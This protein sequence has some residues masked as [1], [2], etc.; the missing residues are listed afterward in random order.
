[1]SASPYQSDEKQL[2]KKRIPTMRKSIK[3]G[4]GG[5]SNVE[6]I[7]REAYQNISPPSIDDLQTV[8]E[9]RNA[10][11]NDLLNKITS[12]DNENSKMGD[13]KPIEHPS[14]NVKRDMDGGQAGNY[15]NTAAKAEYIATMPS[16]GDA[17]NQ[18]KNG[19]FSYSYGGGDSAPIY[20]NYN[21]SYEGSGTLKLPPN[22]NTGSVGRKNNGIEP[23]Y[24]GGGNI[25]YDDKLMERINYMIHLLEE[26]RVEKTS[27][28]TEEFILYSF[29]GI[30][31]IY[32]ID[33][34]A[35]SGK[36]TR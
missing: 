5:V 31:I 3:G 17:S 16:F 26:Q 27:N 8:N 24:G 1:M 2:N 14:L 13:F 30:F 34:F 32:V 4:G 25:R 36:Y 18:M 15:E 28:I 20:S 33:G 19:G 21:Q 35:R 29:L 7:T 22:M 12:Q 23:S 11:V 9:N 6:E 10:R